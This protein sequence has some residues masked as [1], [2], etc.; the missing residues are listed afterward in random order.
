MLGPSSGCSS[1]K[2]MS[3]TCVSAPSIVYSTASPRTTVSC[4]RGGSCRYTFHGPQPSSFVYCPI[5]RSMS[6][7]TTAI[8]EICSCRPSR[9]PATDSALC[10]PSI[11]P[12]RSHCRHAAVGGPHR[13]RRV[14]RP[15]RGEERDHLR[16]LLRRTC[17]PQRDGLQQIL[18]LLRRHPLRHGRARVAGH[19]AVDTDAVVRVVGREDA[20]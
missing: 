7:T 2:P 17:A 12:P 13:S 10:F 9:P 16:H 4:S 3:P 8:C 1:S 5:V 15:R 18:V 14:R 11:T 19:D 6:S 20:H